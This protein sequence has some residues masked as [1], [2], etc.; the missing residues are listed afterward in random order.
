MKSLADW[1]ITY[2]RKTPYVHL[3]DYMSR[4]W[5]VPYKHEH[6]LL[7]KKTPF[8][9]VLQYFNVAIRV[10]EIRKSDSDRAMHN[11]PWNYVSIILKGGY[12]EITPR[13]TAKDDPQDTVAVYHGPGSILFRR[14]RSLHRLELPSLGANEATTLFITFKW[15]QVWGFSP[16]KGV[17]IPH[18]EYLKN[19]GK[20]V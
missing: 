1:I 16:E 14:A 19:K 9:W 18:K 4:W 17:I 15:R 12:Y 5:V 8:K 10:H 7:F 20:E 6:P 2:A 13:V 3:G 11:H